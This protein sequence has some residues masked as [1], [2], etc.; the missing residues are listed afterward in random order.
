MEQARERE[1]ERS[2]Q[3]GRER[4]GAGVEAAGTAWEAG[5]PA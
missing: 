4:V 3:G 2:R 1:R 5:G